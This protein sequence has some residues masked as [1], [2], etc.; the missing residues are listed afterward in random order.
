[1]LLFWGA[2]TQL[3]GGED[4]EADGST[5]TV[6]H[7]GAAPTQ[8]TLNNPKR[9]IEIQKIE[10]LRAAKRIGVRLDSLIFGGKQTSFWW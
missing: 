10:V 2:S 4:F 6:H 8:K 5:L 1:M 3:S 7:L 9:L